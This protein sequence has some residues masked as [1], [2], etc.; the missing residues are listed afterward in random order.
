MWDPEDQLAFNDMSILHNVKQSASCFAVYE[1]QQPELVEDGDSLDQACTSGRTIDETC[2]WTDG[3]M[4]K[5]YPP[6]GLEEGSLC[7]N[8]EDC[9]QSSLCLW[10]SQNSTAKYCTNID[11]VCIGVQEVSVAAMQTFTQ[12]PEA[13]NVLEIS[14]GGLHSVTSL[15]TTGTVINC[16]TQYKLQYLDDTTGEW[17]WYV[18]GVAAE[19]CAEA[20][21]DQ[22]TTAAGWFETSPKLAGCIPHKFAVMRNRIAAPF[23]TRQVRISAEEFSLPSD[24]VRLEVQVSGCQVNVKG[25]DLEQCK[26]DSNCASGHCFQS[27]CLSNHSEAKVCV[28]SQGLPQGYQCCRNDQ[29]A[30]RKCSSSQ[31]QTAV[32]PSGRISFNKPAAAARYCAGEAATDSI[33]YPLEQGSCFPLTTRETEVC[34]EVRA[35]ECR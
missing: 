14:L 28:P 27:E 20:R 15:T 7:C 13:V 6:A 3:H 34:R 2:L 10:S 33:F 18:G 22:L 11:D 8:S 9:E 32:E 25:K 23:V 4:P 24:A 12:L 35:A 5:C 21:C 30:S 26:Q 19:P 17:I 16:V 31:N 29:C 1:Q